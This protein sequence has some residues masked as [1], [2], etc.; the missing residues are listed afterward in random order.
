MSHRARSHTSSTPSSPSAPV[1]L[2]RRGFFAAASSAFL[3]AVAWPK[4]ASAAG[5]S[6][7]AVPLG[8]APKLQSVG[9]SLMTRIRGKELLLVRDGQDS[10][11]TFEAKCPH[12]QCDVSYAADKQK[13]EC[14]CHD[15][16][17]DL[18]GKVLAGPVPRPLET[19][20]TI[21]DGDRILIRIPE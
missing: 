3:A 6:W 12:E 17:F 7:V 15:A 20:Q 18:S 19:Y 2:P 16:L 10:A 1:A 14:P 9:G 8:K 13:L 5:K 11:H 4:A 21:V